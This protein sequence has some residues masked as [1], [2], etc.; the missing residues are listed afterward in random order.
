MLIAGIPVSPD[1]L[2]L[3]RQA[4]HFTESGLLFCKMGQWSSLGGQINRSILSYSKCS[5]NVTII[6]SI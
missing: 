5:R 1:L 3:G 2:R 4:S 6:L